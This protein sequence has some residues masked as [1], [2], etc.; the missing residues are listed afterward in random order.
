LNF[1]RFCAIRSPVKLSP[2]RCTHEKDRD[3]AIFEGLL[4]RVLGPGPRGQSDQRHHGPLRTVGKGSSGKE[5]VPRT[6][7]NY[8]GYAPIGAYLGQKRWCLGMELRPG[9]QHSQNGFVDFLR[10]ALVCT[11]RS[12]A[13]PSW[14]ERT[15]LTM[16]WKRLWSF[17]D[18]PMWALSS[19]GIHRTAFTGVIGPSWRAV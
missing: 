6:Y 19:H 18:T 9:S 11:R 5:G 3:G 2:A 8:D 12:P 1:I 17:A 16:P 13:S 14:C 15:R 7:K 10:K 4:Q